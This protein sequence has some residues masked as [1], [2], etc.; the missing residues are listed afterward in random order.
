MNLRMGP[1]A[2]LVTLLATSCAG[3]SQTHE[4]D[5]AASNGGDSNGGGGASTGGAANP[6]A[7]G[8]AAAGT[9]GAPS[10][11]CPDKQPTPGNACNYAGTGYCIYAIDQCS[12][13]SFECSA[14]L[15]LEVP[16]FDGAAYD[17]NSFGSPS[18]PK[19]GDACE[20]FGRLDCTYDECSGRGRIRAM[21]DNT[22]WHVTE[23]P[24]APQ[25]CG[26]EGLRC[27]TGDVCVA[28]FG[29]FEGSSCVPNPCGAATTNCNCAGSLCKSVELCSANS[30]MVT[31]V[32]APD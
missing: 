17:C 15:W 10:T 12:S 7:A 28:H 6:A 13:V 29:A 11:S 18:A 21:C 5:P 19:D 9:A 27:D 22:S 4:G 16:Q 20:C 32:T 3:K 8:T 30:G 2:L 23:T 31:C 26:N 1:T 24:C 14:Q 25:V